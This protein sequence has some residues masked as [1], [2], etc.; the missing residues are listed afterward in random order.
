MQIKVSLFGIAREIAGQAT[1]SLGMEETAQVS[2]LLE[3]LKD[4]YPEMSKLRSLAVAKNQEYAQ[5]DDMLKENDEIALI[6]PV[7]GG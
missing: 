4:L 1:L 3:K 7:S 2:D 6:P 5:P